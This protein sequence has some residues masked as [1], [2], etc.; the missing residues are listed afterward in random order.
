MNGDFA[1][2]VEPSQTNFIVLYKACEPTHN[3]DTNAIFNML[4]RLSVFKKSQIN[5]ILNK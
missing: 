3:V 4:Y 5:S 2:E 1:A